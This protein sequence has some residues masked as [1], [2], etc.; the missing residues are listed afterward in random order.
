MM[1]KNPL[2]PQT[3]AARLEFLERALGPQ[4]ESAERALQAQR[5]AERAA[6]IRARADELAML[7]AELAKL[8][9]AHAKIGQALDSATRAFR[10]LQDAGARSY[11]DLRVANARRDLIAGQH[12]RVLSGLGGDV[13]AAT[14]YRIGWLA[15]VANDHLGYVPPPETFKMHQRPA[16]FVRLDWSP[17]ELAEVTR[18]ALPEIEAL[19]LSP[20]SPTEI[21]TA[22]ETAL[23][24]C[25]AA[26]GPTVLASA[27]WAT[28]FTAA[29]LAVH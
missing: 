16:D 27:P 8:E 1:M 24:N 6:A 29:A 12:E 26:A 4:I 20:A 2:R 5:A 3:P 7:D 11:H 17:A 18:R 28:T 25:C 13:V 23:A 22:C 19:A 15:K 10:E 14:I 9:K 21:E